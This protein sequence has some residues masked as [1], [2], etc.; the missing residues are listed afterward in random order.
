MNIKYIFTI[1]FVSL[2]KNLTEVLPYYSY[3]SYSQLHNKTKTQDDNPFHYSS[4]TFI[5]T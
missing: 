4:T 1:I 5:L 2:Q 3:S